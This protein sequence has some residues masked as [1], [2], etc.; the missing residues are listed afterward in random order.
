MTNSE[1]LKHFIEQHFAK[2]LDTNTHI[3]YE[4][5]IDFIFENSDFNIIK[6]KSILNTWNL[7]VKDGKI[8]NLFCLT[9]RNINRFEDDEIPDIDSDDD[10]CS[11]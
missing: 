1:T 3:L 11:V 6:V 9:D 2:D 7:D 4:D 10:E 5:L 8:Y